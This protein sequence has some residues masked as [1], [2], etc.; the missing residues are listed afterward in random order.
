[1]QPFWK[2][3][4]LCLHAILYAGAAAMLPA[5]TVNRIPQGSAPSPAVVA[6]TGRLTLGIERTPSTRQHPGYYKTYAANDELLA[7]LR[8]RHAFREVDFLDRLSSPPDLI[9]KNSYC[10]TYHHFYEP[11][12]QTLTFG[13]IPLNGKTPYISEFTLATANGTMICDVQEEH[14]DP[15]V[16]GCLVYPMAL[17]PRWTAGNIDRKAVLDRFAADVERAAYEH[18]Q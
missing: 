15:F 9:M 16:S 10:G 17:S 13:I 14:E 11:M 4:A 8:R 3:P 12:L 1:M 7:A 2:N 18:P 5:C 6:R